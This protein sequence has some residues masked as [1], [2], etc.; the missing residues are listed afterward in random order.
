MTGALNTWTP[1]IADGEIGE[2]PQPVKHVARGSK[3]IAD[4][5]SG[6]NRNKPALW[7]VRVLDYSRW[8]IGEEPQHLARSYILRVIIADGRSG[9]NRNMWLL[10]SSQVRI[11]ADGRSGRNRNTVEPGTRAMIIIADGRSGRNH[12]LL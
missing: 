4:G 5:R 8:E 3:I 10:L 2:E 11:I 7:G 6:R 9:R 12:N 1:I